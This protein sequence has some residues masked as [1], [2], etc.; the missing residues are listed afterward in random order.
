MDLKGFGCS[1]GVSFVKPMLIVLLLG[2]PRELGSFTC[3]SSHGLGNGQVGFSGPRVNAREHC[4]S[5]PR[6]SARRGGGVPS[7]P[8]A[9][10]RSAA[11]P[12]ASFCLHWGFGQLGG[13]IIQ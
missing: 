5:V 13:E 8:R 3:S 6:L 9:W 12:P 2:A 7:S 1:S 4:D 11:R 10:G